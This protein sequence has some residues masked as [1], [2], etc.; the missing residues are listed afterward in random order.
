MTGD[1]HEMAHKGAYIG[2]YTALVPAGVAGLWFLSVPFAIFVA[3]FTIPVGIFVGSAVGSLLALVVAWRHSTTCDA[4]GS[5]QSAASSLYAARHD[6]MLKIQN[7][8]GPIGAMFGAAVLGGVVFTSAA[9]V[10]LLSH[11]QQ[12]SADT[13]TT[14]VITIL[15]WPTLIA[16]A[17]GALLGF[18]CGAFSAKHS[19]ASQ[20]YSCNKH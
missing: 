12:G 1:I 16:V 11:L 6:I 13:T 17:L 15:L 9:F 3:L 19:Y 7:L 14:T 10:V 20:R 2:I 18:I 4:A 8:N 5:E